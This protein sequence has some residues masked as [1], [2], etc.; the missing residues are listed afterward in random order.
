[1][2]ERPWIELELDALQIGDAVDRGFDRPRHQRLDLL[3]GKAGRLGLDVHLRRGEFWKGV[4][5]RVVEHI[6]AVGDEQAGKHDDDAAK[7]QRE[8]NDRGLQAG[9]V[10]RQ[11]STGTEARNSSDSSI[12]VPWMTTR[13]SGARPPTM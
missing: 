9:D 7:A 5:A 6:D 1:M 10:H 4:I 8:A 12:C 3:G 2:S 11:S 13:A